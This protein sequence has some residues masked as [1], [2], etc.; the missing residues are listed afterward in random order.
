MP[1]HFHFVIK[2]NKDDHLSK[3]MQ[4]VLTSQVRRHNLKYRTTGHVWQG[5]FKSFIVKNDY[6]LLTLLRYVERNPI[7]AHLV[8]EASSWLWSSY[9]E[10][11]DPPKLI[12]SPPIPIPHNWEELVNSPLTPS[13]V[14]KISVCIKKQ[15]PYGN[16]EW[17]F[18]TCHKYG[19]I[20][21]M[22]SVGRPPRCNR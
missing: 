11:Y 13:E 10:R 18:R 6:H 3:F 20:H 17:Q 19:M 5:R 4:W 2:S 12:T 9:Q 21:T 1:N 22:R 14:E 8:S 7:A 15:S 16:K